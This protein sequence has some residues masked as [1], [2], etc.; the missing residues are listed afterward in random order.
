M[1]KIIQWQQIDTVL[2]DMDGTLLDLHFDNYFWL[3]YVPQEYAKKYQLTIEQAKAFL[4]P[5]FKSFEGT[6]NWYCI[7]HWTKELNLDIALLKSEIDHLIQVHPHVI[8][9][10][11]KLKSLQK[12]VILVTN[13]HQKILSLKMEKTQLQGLFEQSISA[14]DLG[15]P[16]ENS[17]FWDKLQQIV[18]FDKKRTLFVDDGVKMLE[19]AQQYGIQWLMAILKPDS[20][21]APNQSKYFYGI[22][23]F[24]EVI[25]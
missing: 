1:E 15:I 9:F 6:L 17:D 12:K 8:D 4:F 11:K 16:K 14:H 21:L 22:N 3:T 23:D 7:D 5:L 20:T 13:A 24:S 25:W 2:L 10:L 19:S 18:P